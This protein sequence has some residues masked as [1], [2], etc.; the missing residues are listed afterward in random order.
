MRFCNTLETTCKYRSSA[1]PLYSRG[2]CF[3]CT[4]VGTMDQVEDSSSSFSL[5]VNQ[6]LWERSP[7][8]FQNIQ[9]CNKLW[10]N[11][12]KSYL[13]LYHSPQS[14]LFFSST[15]TQNLFF[16]VQFSLELAATS[17]KQHQFSV[18]VQSQGHIQL[19]HLANISH[20]VHT[21]SLFRR[22]TTIS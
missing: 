22:L 14:T 6:T 5:L 9:I 20:P 18:Q 15:Q 17:S 10:L 1:F 16:L 7:Q 12:R 11:C 21:I 13:T 8:R 19:N 3:S 4:H 2:Q